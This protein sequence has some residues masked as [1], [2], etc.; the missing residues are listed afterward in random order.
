MNRGQKQRRLRQQQVREWHKTTTAGKQN[1]EN[2]MKTKKKFKH[3]KHIKETKKL[4]KKRGQPWT[5]NAPRTQ[6]Q[7]P[8]TN[9]LPNNN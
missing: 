1:Q 4:Q 9:T 7:G 3:V 8:R 2:T 6:G 5:D